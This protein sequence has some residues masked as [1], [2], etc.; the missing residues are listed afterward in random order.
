VVNYL[1]KERSILYKIF[2]FLILTTYRFDNYFHL[3]DLI[4]NDIILQNA[5]QSLF[6]RRSH[7]AFI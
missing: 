2:R 6:L 1:K 5:N 7:E 4:K 3:N